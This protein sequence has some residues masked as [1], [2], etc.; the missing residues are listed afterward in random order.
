MVA[1]YVRA[2]DRFNFDE[3]HALGL[4]EGVRPSMDRFVI[5]MTSYD[6]LIHPRPVDQIF[7]Q[8]LK[9]RIG[10]PSPQNVLL[11]RQRP[12]RRIHRR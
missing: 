7:N 4:L 2:R 8:T 3:P 5:H 9:R 11:S 6:T 1:W 10:I 12:R